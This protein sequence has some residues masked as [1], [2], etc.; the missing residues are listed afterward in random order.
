MLLGKDQSLLLPLSCLS[1]SFSLPFFLSPHWYLLSQ[2]HLMNGLFF[3][4][5]LRTR[6]ENPFIKYLWIY[7]WYL[8]PLVSLFL[9]QSHIVP[10]TNFTVNTEL[11]NG[12]VSN[13]VFLF[14]IV[15]TI[16][17]SPRFPRY[18]RCQLPNPTI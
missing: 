1:V 5:Y 4:H 16:L 14:K 3:P 15:W 6:V 17:Y 13:F 18:F 10:I 2:H 9:C 12:A 8:V 11:R 7:L